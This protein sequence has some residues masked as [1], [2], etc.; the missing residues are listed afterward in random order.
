MKH[1]S[2]PAKPAERARPRH[3]TELRIGATLKIIGDDSLA[4]AYASRRAVRRSALV[5]FVDPAIQAGGHA[6]ETMA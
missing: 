1:P 4:I 2:V 3:G 6:I 5:P